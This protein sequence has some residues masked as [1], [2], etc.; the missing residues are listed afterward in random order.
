MADVKM[1]DLLHRLNLL[2]ALTAIMLALPAFAASPVIT[3]VTAQQR[4]PWNGLVDIAVTFNGEQGDV[5]KANCVFA[6][7]NSAT[8]AALTIAHVTPQ[9]GATGSGTAWTRRFVWDTNADL[10]EVKID[11]V[12]LLANVEAVDEPSVAGGV[13]L[14]KDGPYWSEYNVGASK[15][16][17]YGLYFWWGDTVGHAK[18]GSWFRSDSC[19][20]YGKTLAEL[21]S[22]G[23]IDSSEILRPEHD[24]A[25]EHLGLPWRMPT[26]EEIK[27]LSENCDTKWITR[28]GVSGRL[29]T[30]RGEFSSNSIFLPA[31]G[32][33]TASYIDGVG[34]SCYY[35]SSS[36]EH[37]NYTSEFAWDLC[38]TSSWLDGRSNVYYCNRGL[39]VRP[40]RGLAK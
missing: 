25:T 36:I 39:S 7:T 19:P 35:W 23:Y 38:A 26:R 21:M 16:E 2:V 9:G 3:S 28:N 11:D 13:Q 30:G 29:V 8:K 12:E 10:G 14:W 6:A 27:A 40:V 1:K 32:Y 18:A 24:A 4:Y 20:T 33:G 37:T 34:S 5:A 22:L 31:A 15:P 17:E